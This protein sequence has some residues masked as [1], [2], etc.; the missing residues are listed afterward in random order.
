MASTV[1]KS[2]GA[3]KAEKKAKKR[4]ENDGVHKDKK[5]KKEKKKAKEQL[6]QVLDEHLQ[7]S[8]AASMDV[9]DSDDQKESVATVIRGAIVEFAKPMANDKHQKKIFKCIKKGTLHFSLCDWQLISASSP[10]PTPLACRLYSLLPASLP[11]PSPLSR[12][13]HH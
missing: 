11:P 8:A 10:P 4:S 7:A 9:D 6:V 13:P 2:E 1:A 5:E 12:D 3:S